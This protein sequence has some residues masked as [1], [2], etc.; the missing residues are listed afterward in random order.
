MAWDK[1]K[2]GNVKLRVGRQQ[3]LTNNDALETALNR[4]HNF[5][6]LQ[7][8]MTANI[9]KLPFMLRLLMAQPRKLTKDFYI[10]RMFLQKPSFSLRMRTDTKSS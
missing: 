6:V 5:P 4:D 9:L 10:L 1:N 7:R 8:R 3:I 2:P